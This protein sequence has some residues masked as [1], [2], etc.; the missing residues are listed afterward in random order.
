[1][2]QPEIPA[3]TG[4]IG[5]LCVGADCELH[6]IKPMRFLIND[7]YLKRAGLDYW[8][9][10][11]FHTHQS[12]QE[13]KINY[14]HCTL[15]YCTT[16]TPR[17]YTEP[18]YK[19]GDAFV[20]GPESRGI[21]EDILTENCPETITIPMSDQLRSLNLSNS[22]AVVLYEALRQTGYTGNN[23]ERRIIC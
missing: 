10:L 23:L 22:V 8:N 14:P 1:L 7:K 19:P 2:Y 21:P 20:F 4:N 18:D 5:R 9:K 16:K 11:K 3:N 15:Y 13:L 12:L 17:L 6:I